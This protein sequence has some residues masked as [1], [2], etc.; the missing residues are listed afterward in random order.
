[1]S[2]PLISVIIQSHNRPHFLLNH[3]IPSVINQSLSDWELI[4][5]GDGPDDNQ[6]RNIV[7]SFS[8]SRIK[9]IEIERP[10][11]NDLSEEALCNCSGAEARNRGLQIACGKYIAPLE[12]DSEFTINHLLESITFLE[13]YP[14]DFVYGS[15]IIRDCEFENEYTDFISWEKNVKEGLFPHINIMYHSSVLYRSKYKTLCYPT[16][17]DISAELGLWRKIYSEGAKIG[18]LSTPQSIFYKP[19]GEIKVRI[20]IPFTPSIEDYSAVIKNVYQ[21][22]ILSNKGP[23]ATEFESLVGKYLQCPYVSNTSSGDAGLIASLQVI[24]KFISSGQNEVILPSYTFPATANAVIWNGFKPVFADICPEHLGLSVGTIEPLITKNT[25]CI[26]PVHSHGNPVDIDSIVD[27]AQLYKLQIVWDSASAFGAKYK[28]RP[29]GASFGLNVFS[30]SGTKTISTGEGGAISYTDEIY[31]EPIK[32][33]CNYGFLENYQCNTL[34][35]NAK[36]SEFH[37]GMGILTIPK[38]DYLISL[39]QKISQ[40]YQ[41]NLKDIPEVRFQGQAHPSVIPSHKDMPLLFSNS[42]L[43]KKVK[44]SLEAHGIQ[45]KPYYR[46]LHLMPLFHQFIN[47][48]LPITENSGDRVLC[49]PIF[50]LMTFNLVD[51]ICQIIRDQ[52]SGRWV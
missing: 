4:V 26:L 17:G 22:K 19:A 9:Y 33:S 2:K 20:N 37:A 12:D 52:V 34:G 46:P 10:D 32:A 44:A 15:T 40:R 45:T 1:M 50:H 6:I 39:K 24:K 38:T 30:F 21:S 35:I 29:V 31:K 41:Y 25:A 51:F 47:K 42:I 28:G 43:A 5:V 11:Y 3:S 14:L 27:L 23:L 13:K 48:E 8:D 49:V 18:G 16:N 7:N 36:M